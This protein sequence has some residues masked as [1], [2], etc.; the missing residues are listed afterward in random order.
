MWKCVENWGKVLCGKLGIF[1]DVPEMPYHQLLTLK[2][3]QDTHLE[4]CHFHFFLFF[5]SPTSAEKTTFKKLKHISGKKMSASDSEEEEIPGTPKLVLET[6]TTS[7]PK[8]IPRLE[9]FKH[10]IKQ[11]QGKT[12]KI[13]LKDLEFYQEQ[14]L[15]QI[16]REELTRKKV[17]QFVKTQKWKKVRGNDHEIFNHITNHDGNDYEHLEAF[18]IDDFKYFSLAFNDLRP[19]RQ[20]FLNYE[21]VLFALLKKNGFHPNEDDFKLLILPSRRAEQEKII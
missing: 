17:R 18:L 6:F 9:H 12:H 15:S 14:I 10:I 16:P 4:K 7:I 11:N 2:S 21:Q 13:P 20:K 8:K 5:S 1:D 19:N 3:A